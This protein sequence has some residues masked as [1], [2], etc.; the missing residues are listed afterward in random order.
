MGD[1]ESALK[2]LQLTGINF[3][4]KELTVTRHANAAN[5]QLAIA[6]NP[7]ATTTPG[8]SEALLAQQ[9]VC[10]LLNMFQERG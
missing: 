4:G 2:A 10:F 7:A 5:S 3:M 6:S 1:P 9:E 8:Y